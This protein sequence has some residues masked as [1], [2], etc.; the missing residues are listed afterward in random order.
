MQQG[1]VIAY[2][3]EAVWGLGCNPFDLQAVTKILTLKDRPVEKGLIVL[4]SSITRL[5]PLLKHLSDSQIELLEST[6]PA[7]V[8]FVIED[9][10][11]FFPSYVR[12]QFSSIAVRVS[13]SA[14]LNRLVDACGGLLIST[15]ANPA[16]LAPG[17]TES[18]VFEYFGGNI[19]CYVD[20]DIDT[21]GTP[22]KIIRLSDSAVLRA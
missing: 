14:R 4:A 19:D 17:L 2:P 21:E 13:D 22:S 7:A 1:R 10:E 12:G 18:E 16:G 8:T 3:A 15:S 5:E 6:W 9:P 20:G 11:A